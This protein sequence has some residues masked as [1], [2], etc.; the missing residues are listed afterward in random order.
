MLDVF[1][2]CTKCGQSYSKSDILT[3]CSRCGGALFYRFNLEEISE[4]FPR[5][6]FEEREDTFWKFSE[7][8]PLSSKENIVSLGEP[9]TPILSLSKGHQ[10]CLK[11]IFVKDDGRL[12]TGTFKSRGIAVA[13][14]ALKEKGV[15]QVSIPS[16]GN[17]AAALTAYGTKAGM[18]VHAFMPVDVPENILK[19]CIFGGA[20][21]YLVNGLITEAAEIAKKLGKEKGWFDVSTNKQ[22]YRFEGYKAGAF[23]IAEQLNWDLPEVILFPTGG[24]EGIIGLWKGFKELVDLHWT[25]KMPRLV[26]VQSS[27]CAPIVEA[28]ERKQTEVKDRW[29]NPETIADGLRVPM[30]FASY[31]ILQALKETKGLA[32]AVD[33]D[34]IISSIKIFL[35]E[36]IYAGPEAST[37][38][39]ALKKLSRQGSF[40]A[41]DRILLYITGTAMK[42]FELLEIEKEKLPVLTKESAISN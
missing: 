31:L 40:N 35:K 26:V 10:I 2:Q 25:R 22:P 24:G 9:Y 27:G 15:S 5:R 12:P 20:V 38:M 19:E 41:D 34:E 3:V 16:A 23:E 29:K 21:V 14:S 37:P 33:A 42:S 4:R 32:V 1:V 11:N 36:G 39:A 13:V 18:E 30:P 28:F 7:F 6:I 8:L 17:A